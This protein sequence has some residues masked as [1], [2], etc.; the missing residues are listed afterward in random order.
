MN[1][2]IL[3]IG[4][5]PIIADLTEQYR[6]RGDVVVVGTLDQVLG[7]PDIALFK[8]FVILADYNKEEL[9]ADDEAM[10]ILR[11][12]AEDDYLATNRG[13]RP[14]C[15]LLLRNNSVLHLIRLEGFRKEIEERLEVCPFTMV[16]Q[17][18][19]AIAISLDREPITKQSEKI[20]HLVIFG[21]SEVA[22]QVA[23]NAAQVCHY[24]NY[25]QKEHTLRTRITLI[26][27]S[28]IEKSSE[29]IQRYKN[30]FDN[31]FYR[32][33]DTKKTP[34]VIKTSMPMYVDR[35]DFVDI[36]WEFVSA[37]AY[38]KLVRDKITKWA[39]SSSQ[40]LSVVFANEDSGKGLSE[41]L[42][43]P[44]AIVLTQ[45]PVYVYMQGDKAFR[46]IK[47]TINSPNI[48]PFG[49]VDH[50]YDVNIPII[51]MAKNVNFI[52]N[53]CYEE[54]EKEWN[55]H[56]RFSVEIGEN[57]KESLWTKKSSVK[58]MSNM[59]NA[60]TISPK[61]RSMG[62]H[63]DDW[64]KFYELS[65]EDIE[66]LAE[67]EHNRWNVEELILGFRPCN[68]DELK[69]IAD[70]IENHNRKRIEV[71]NDAVKHDKTLKEIYK[72]E[73][74]AHYDIRAYNDLRPDGTGRPVQIYDRC[75]SACIPLIA[76][77]S[78]EGGV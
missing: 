68:D 31:C 17:W 30:L 48:I 76:K 67:V 16:D 49:M 24:P 9:D 77:E 21:M 2:K 50:G 12:I 32:F 69:E 54:N 10:G 59:Y 37:S 74:K 25:L 63:Y 45:T 20:V 55:G 19:Q 39:T 1:N 70:S 4:N 7:K 60:M 71:G 62:F 44:E 51:K 3:I 8:E 33:V 42:R 29:W 56:L 78:K 5:H 11:R 65:E 73:R 18:S 6:Q 47:H 23:I 46:Q 14:L 15:H 61:M 43:L 28:A 27:E 40:L 41:A 26:D 34:A 57:E 22:E 53:R 38:D 13:Q 52:Y 58:R 66:I 64:D 35:E 72:E 36:E 75:L